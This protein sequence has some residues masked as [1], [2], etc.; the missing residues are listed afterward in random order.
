MIHIAILGYGVVGSG[1]AEVC[2]MNQELMRQRTGFAL[3]V[4]K[5]LDIR[6]F[7]GDPF[8]DR[9]T[10]NPDEIF[11]DPDISVV[12]ETIGGTGVARDLS[13]RALKGGKHLVSSNKELVAS[14]GPELMKLARQHQVQY[15]FEASVGGGIPIIRPL[16]KTLAVNEISSIVG[17]LNGT[18]N[19]ILSRMASGGIDFDQALAEAQEQGYAEQNPAQDLNGSDTCRKLAI[20]SSISTGQYMNYA[21]IYTEGI[22]R[23]QRTDQAYA[24][25][26]KTKLK[27][28][29]RFRLLA[30]HR[31]DLIVA[32]MLVPQDHP[33]SVADGV[34][35]AILIEGNALGKAMFY[36][37]GA[38]KLPTA[39]AVVADVIS[40]GM[41]TDHD[42]RYLSE[43]VRSDQSP[44]VPHADCLVQALVRF[45]SD[46]PASRIQAAFAPFGAEPVAAQ[47][48][49]EQA[50]LVGQA[51]PMTEQQLADL[52]ASFG[53][54]VLQ[55]LRLF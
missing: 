19:Y 27:L 2:R 28:I 51:G 26:L 45:R 35:N 8:E 10:Q 12:V 22:S 1:V 34:N 42:V 40:C 43:W 7:P 16:Y 53:Q 47:E 50:W 11:S 37:Q 46:L 9:I 13:I 29:A 24:R 5:I 14:Y 25:L 15:Y 38:G 30:D 49:T 6:P 36:G 33:V 48:K 52:L 17:I 44:L 55:R 23:I 4:K 32:P 41:K 39:S 31:V 3:N 18:T 20:L 54:A 21:D